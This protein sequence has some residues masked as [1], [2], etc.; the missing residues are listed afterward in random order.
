M[1][2]GTRVQN[3][4]NSVPALRME[5]EAGGSLEVILVYIASIR[6]AKSYIVRVLLKIINKKVSPEARHGGT[7]L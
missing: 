7:C 6:T 2:S 5:A 1:G 3:K 4:S